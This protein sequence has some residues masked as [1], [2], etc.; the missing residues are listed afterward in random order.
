MELW[1]AVERGNLKEAEKLLK[2]GYDPNRVS[3]IYPI[4]NLKILELFVKYGLDKKFCFKKAIIRSEY[5]TVK[6]LL[7]HGV[8]PNTLDENGTHCLGIF[9]ERVLK[10]LFSYGANVN[11]EDKF[12]N[13]IFDNYIR[14]GY[15]PHEN[16][17]LEYMVKNGARLKY[18]PQL[19]KFPWLLKV[20]AR[21]RWVIIKCLTKFLSLHQRAV[22][23]ANAP[24]RKLARGEFKE[25]PQ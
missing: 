13:T 4:E 5:K 22:V 23:T 16:K 12:G 17:M 2:A 25:E 20:W 6:W 8:E 19:K 15:T 21:R 18:I 14:F 7:E 9:N 1:N 3:L 10:C 24:L 11:L